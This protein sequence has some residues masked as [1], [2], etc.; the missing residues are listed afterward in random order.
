MA[1]TNLSSPGKTAVYESLYLISLAVQQI[2]D[3]LERLKSTKILAPGFVELR[4]M[5]ANQLRAEIAASSTIN[6]TT[7]EAED[8]YRLERKRIR[9]EKK[10]A[11][12]GTK[13]KA[14]RR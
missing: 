5:A 9:M 10:V 4:K 13:R 8:A 12:I 2:T 14:A 6:L 11:Q 3:S 1:T 7:R